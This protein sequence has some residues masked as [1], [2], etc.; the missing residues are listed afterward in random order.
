MFETVSGGF[1]V[2]QPGSQLSINAVEGFPL[3]D[4]S[5]GTFPCSGMLHPAHHT[6]RAPVDAVRN[7]ICAYTRAEIPLNERTDRVA[8]YSGIPESRGM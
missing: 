5:A 7:Q 3:E 1:A 6:D 8:N 2:V 4:F